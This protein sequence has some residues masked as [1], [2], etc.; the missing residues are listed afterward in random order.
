MSKFKFLLN[1][2]VPV[3]IAAGSAAIA[4]GVKFYHFQH[5]YRLTTFEAGSSIPNRLVCFIFHRPNRSKFKFLL[6]NNVPV[7]IAAGSAAIAAGVKFYYF[8]HNYRL[9]TIKA[10]SSIPN[11]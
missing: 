7:A 11:R 3:A 6:N 8:Q 4:A 5:N 2:N 9:T 1:N 10:G